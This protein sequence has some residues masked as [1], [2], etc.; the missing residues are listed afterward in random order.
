MVALRLIGALPAVSACVALGLLSG[1]VADG[2]PRLD[3]FAE[4]GPARAASAPALRF[5][6]ASG[7]YLAGRYARNTRDFNAAAEFLSD[8]LS[9]DA[10][11]SRIRRQV[12]FS[13]AAAGKMDAAGN[14]AAEV[15]RDDKTSPVPNLTLIVATIRAGDHEGALA[16]LETL[17]KIGMNTFTAPLLKAW[18]LVGQEKYEDAIKAVEP[19]AKVSAFR[20]LRL[21]HTALIEDL[22]GNADAAEKAFQGALK[23]VKSARTV[24][25]YGRFLERAGRPEE[26]RT[27][28]D[29]YIKSNGGTSLQLEGDVARLDAK[30]S[31]LRIVE[32]SMDG[33]AEALFNLSG[34]LGQSRSV[35]LA[36]IYSRLALWIKPVFPQAKILVGDLLD[37][38][39]RREE[40]L[41][42][43]ASVEKTSSHYWGARLRRATILNTLK[44][45]DEAE[46]LLRGM[47]E[48]EPQRSDALIQL[49][50][51][52]RAADKFEDAS[53]AY[54]RAIERT[55]DLREEDWSLFYSRGIT[56]ERSKK[57]A[58]AEK[59]FLRALELRPDQPF[60]LNYLGYSWV[61]QGRNLDR[62]KK[63]IQEAVRRRPN[64]GYI[65]D[66]LGWV[67]YRLGDFKGATRQ[68]ERAV[69]L[70][71]ED[72]TINDHLGDAYWRVGRRLEARFQWRRALSLEPEADQVPLIE[73]KLRR[74]MADLPAQ[75]NKG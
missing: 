67:L 10:E 52:L 17:P 29:D 58:L 27:L 66:S 13:L 38:L 56:Y 50:D 21:H 57:W 12:F 75:G 49:G 55:G 3:T 25:A 37:I 68:L 9:Q 15:L 69:T 59:D 73:K 40:A 4:A 18:L 2:Q 70:R 19:L 42:A 45:D 5:D 33:I 41:S 7:N 44:R 51:M 26:A 28:Y 1:C 30:E 53:E 61:D 32:T 47:A 72:P 35:D 16:K 71:P 39:E 6:S 8:A 22:A 65:V 63:M 54:S 14:L 11:N 48:E 23:S 64:D 34:T 24:Q 60:V 46:T 36:L 31:A 62:A 20:A 43:F 74:G